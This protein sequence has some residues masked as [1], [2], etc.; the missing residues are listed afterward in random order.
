MSTGPVVG[1]EVLGKWQQLSCST[2]AD[3][4]VDFVAR[5]MRKQFQH[6]PASGLVNEDRSEALVAGRPDVVGIA[7]GVRHV[8]D[9]LKPF[10]THIGALIGTL[11]CDNCGTHGRDGDDRVL[12]TDETMEPSLPLI[13]QQAEQ[14][15]AD[16]LRASDWKRGRTARPDRC[17][18]GAGH[19]TRCVLIE[20]E[21]FAGM[22]DPGKAS[23]GHWS[24]VVSGQQ[25]R[26]FGNRNHTLVDPPERREERCRGQTRSIL[27]NCV[28]ITQLRQTRGRR[29]K[30]PDLRSGGYDRASVR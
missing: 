29:G 3:E 26:H 9:Q 10:L 22:K 7:A 5:Q 6:R 17:V 19:R 2:V 30:R 11:P 14:D 28:E 23:Q 1:G 16:L 12:E 25:R 27:C 18:K 24:T 13:R 8:P 21:P 15:G 20:L 4:A